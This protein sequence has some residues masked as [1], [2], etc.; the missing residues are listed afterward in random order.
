VEERFALE[1]FDAYGR[2]D[3][4]AAAAAWEKGVTV[5]R[6]SYS[7]EEAERHLAALHFEPYRQS[8]Q[9]HVEEDRLAART[10]S[11]FLQASEAYAQGHFLDA[12]QA[13]RQVAVLNPDYPQLGP[14]LAQAEAA[15]DKERARRLG[16]QKQKEIAQYFD[17][18]VAALEHERYAEAE[19]AFQKVLGLDA[20]HPQARS[21]LSMTQAELRRRHDPQA[22][23]QHYEVG[24]VA[25]ASGKLEEALREWNIAVRM[26]PGHPK[27]LNALS[28]VEKEL[29]LNKEARDEALP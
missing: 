6:Q 11:L 22:A 4:A 18:G 8:A 28:K 24:L 9:A 5:V 15:V 26:N 17:S 2:A 7:R 20:A 13:F 14:F 10:Q 19:R 29:A 23:Q 25:Y 27:A 1:G 21:Y 3:Y 16:E 12:L